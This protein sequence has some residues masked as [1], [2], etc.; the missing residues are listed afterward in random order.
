MEGHSARVNRVVMS[1]DG[2]R[3][4][5]ASDDATYAEP[6]LVGILP[7]ALPVLDV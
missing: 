7:G 6:A 2:Q 1:Q 5:S 4:V 3:L